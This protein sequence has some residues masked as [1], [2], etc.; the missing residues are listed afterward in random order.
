[1][2]LRALQI[3]AERGA[4]PGRSLLDRQTDGLLFTLALANFER[5]AGAALGNDHP[6]VIRYRTAVPD[7]KH[8][9]DMLSH[10]D[11]YIDSRGRLQASGD[12]TAF[13]LAF[14]YDGSTPIVM[15]GNKV[16]RVADALRAADRLHMAVIVSDLGG[17]GGFLADGGG[18]G[19]YRRR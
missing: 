4:A 9:R 14:A 12:V 16:L 17:D 1:M 10:F 15:I 5:A 11:D 2:W 3:E 7:G 8:L 13:T 18:S 6:E 19:P